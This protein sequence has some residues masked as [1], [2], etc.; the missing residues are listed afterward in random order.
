VKAKKTEI[1]IVLEFAPNQAESTQGMGV[2]E[3]FLVLEC[4]LDSDQIFN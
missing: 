4:W 2:D 3:A 1:L